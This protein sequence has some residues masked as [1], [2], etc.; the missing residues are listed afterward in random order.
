M[1]GVTE[2]PWVSWR[3]AVIKDAR[4]RQQRRQR[5]ILAITTVLLSV[6]AIGWALRHSSRSADGPGLSP[7][8][9]TRVEQLHLGGLARDA[10][11]LGASVWVLTCRRD[12]SEASAARSTG[13]IIQLARNGRPLR[14]FAVADPTAIAGGAGAIWI[15]HF[16]TGQ[17]SRV[18][19]RTG[20]TLTIELRF[21]KP[22]ASKPVGFQPLG[23]SFGAGSVWVSSPFGYVAE[24]NPHTVRLERMVFTSSEVTSATTAGGLTWVADELDGVGAFSPGSRRVAIHPVSWARGPVAV[25]TV[26]RGAGLVWALGA[27]TSYQQSLTD[28]TTTGVVTTLNPRTGRIVQQW[29]V[30]ADVSGL[31]LARGVGYAG[32]DRHGWLF[33]LTPQGVETMRGPKAAILAAA[34]RDALWAIGPKGQLLRIALTHR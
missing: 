8:R 13:Q 18:N 20:Q 6:A 11:T 4:R 24:I 31:V 23:V 9:V 32:D 19:P 22:I 10:T 16:D 26:V 12:C 14:R 1:L 3:R 29:R 5:R 27:E 30:P 34:S 21:A 7:V 17:L 33:R 28:P 15:A 25:Q 2:R